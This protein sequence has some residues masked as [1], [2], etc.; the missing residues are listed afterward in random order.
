MSDVVSPAPGLAGA[1][2][3]ALAR[4]TERERRLVFLTAGVAV[5]LVVVGIG[6]GISS[7]IA[8][9]EK[10]IATRQQE[11]T[12]LETLRSDYEAATNRQK[13][14]TARITQSASTSLFTL[15]QKAA[16]DVG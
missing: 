7:A 16:G 1:V 4:M 5:V 14:A 2:S 10:Q 12:Q 15:M 6:W 11:I 13:A 9:R 3:A 8:R